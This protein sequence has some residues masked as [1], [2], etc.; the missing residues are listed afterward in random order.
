MS[1]N[2]SDT[3]RRGCVFFQSEAK[4]QVVSEAQDNSR[5]DDDVRWQPSGA[6]QIAKGN[7]QGEAF[8]N[9]RP[10]Q[11]QRQLRLGWA[12]FQHRVNAQTVKAENLR[13]GF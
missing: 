7:P 12:A 1:S 3:A 5:K 9:S 10:A 4:P 8:I 13:T 2:D 6:R 11:R